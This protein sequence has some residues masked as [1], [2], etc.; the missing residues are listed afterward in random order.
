M[1]LDDKDNFGRPHLGAV[2]ART[3]IKTTASRPTPTRLINFRVL[4]HIQVTRSLFVFG[5]ANWEYRD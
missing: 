5:T 4:L 2:M 3:A 1:A